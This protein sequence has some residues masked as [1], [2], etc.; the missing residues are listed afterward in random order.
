MA[1]SMLKTRWKKTKQRARFKMFD[2]FKPLS[3]KASVYADSPKPVKTVP[4]S[5]PQGRKGTGLSDCPPG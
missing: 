4:Y 2:A 5:G 1:S 3:K